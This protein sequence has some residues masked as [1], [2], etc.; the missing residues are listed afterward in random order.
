M[1][2]TVKVPGVYEVLIIIS[3]QHNTIEHRLMMMDVDGTI[4]EHL[5]MV[6]DGLIPQTASNSAKTISSL[7]VMQPQN[8]S[9]RYKIEL[10]E[11]FQC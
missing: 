1:E 2:L 8:P 7:C 10:D 4:V 5:E 6:L 3:M 9:V 11:N